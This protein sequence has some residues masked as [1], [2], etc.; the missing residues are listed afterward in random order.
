M[1]NGKPNPR[2]RLP[3]DMAGVV[4]AIEFGKIPDPDFESLRL[5]SRSLSGVTEPSLSAVTKT[6]LRPGCRPTCGSRA[7]LALGKWGGGGR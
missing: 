2:E 7:A 1:P 3:V 4:Y 6:A 5:S